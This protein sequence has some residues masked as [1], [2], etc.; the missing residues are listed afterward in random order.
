MIV[1]TVD[2]G[3]ETYRQLASHSELNAGTN[4]L[5]CTAMTK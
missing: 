4:M 5:R 1:D 2:Q 3:L